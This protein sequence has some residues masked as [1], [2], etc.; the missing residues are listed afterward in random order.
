MALACPDV[1]WRGDKAIAEYMVVRKIEIRDE[2]IS[3][4]TP[5]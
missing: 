3:Q 1:S 4:A 5:Q 2:R